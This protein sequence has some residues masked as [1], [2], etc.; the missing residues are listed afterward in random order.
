MAEHY[1]SSSFSSMSDLTFV[2]GTS[3]IFTAELISSNENIPVKTESEASGP[4]NPEQE[5]EFSNV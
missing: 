2:D 4:S 1:L 5:V 3:T